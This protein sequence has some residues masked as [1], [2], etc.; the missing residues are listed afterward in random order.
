MF[1]K[2]FKTW[3]ESG[4][5]PSAYDSSELEIQQDFQT[6]KT[7]FSWQSVLA[8]LVSNSRRDVQ[9]LQPGDGTMRLELFRWG[10]DDCRLLRFIL[11]TDEA[12]YSRE[13][14]NDTRSSHQALLVCQRMVRYHP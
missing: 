12:T 8:R 7:S 13:G 9:H 11:I 5:R 4:T 2:F 3:R 1:Y 14:T 6:L 10:N